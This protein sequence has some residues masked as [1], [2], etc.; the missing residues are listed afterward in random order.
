MSMLMLAELVGR[1]E[2]DSGAPISVARCNASGTVNALAAGQWLNGRPVSVDDRFY[3]ASL[4]KQ[5][6]GAALALLVRDELLDPDL[7]IA[8][9]IGGLPAWSTDITP[10]RLANHTAGLP[11]AGELE[12]RASD[13]W[14]EEFALGALAGLLELPMPPGSAYAYSNLGYVLIARIIAKVS[15]VPFAE[16][17][18]TRLFAPLEIEGIGFLDAPATQPQLPLMGHKLP[19]THGDG[20]LWSTASAFAR[21]LHLQNRDALGVG[22]IVEAPG[23]LEGGGTSA[24][25]WGIGLRTYRGHRLLIHAGEWTGCAGKSVRCPDLGIAVVVLAAATRFETVDR[26]VLDILDDAASGS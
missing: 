21:W 22:A 4:A 11:S 7:P 9:Y 5:V 19:L 16:F 6:T 10:R 14:T 1:S 23:Q 2:R 24:Y 15:G 13:D 26:L 12:A 17:A 25:G 18:A 8:T 3:G 20:G